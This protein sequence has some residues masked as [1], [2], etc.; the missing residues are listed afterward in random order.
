M[1]ADFS[2]ILSPADSAMSEL[3]IKSQTRRY[4]LSAVSSYGIQL[5]PSQF[6]FM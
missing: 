3:V 5:A 6:A 4:H 2:E 1:L